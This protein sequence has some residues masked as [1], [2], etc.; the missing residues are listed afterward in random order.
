M[1]GEDFAY[2][3]NVVP[4]FYFRLGTSKPGTTSGG[5]HTPTFRGDDTAIAVGVRAMSR[6]LV[7]Y[8]QAHPAAEPAR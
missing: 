4:G 7:D 6:V 5:L 2:F 3:A 8:L 1:G